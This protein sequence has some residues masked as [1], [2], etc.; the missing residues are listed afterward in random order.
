MTLRQ[1]RWLLRGVAASCVLAAVALVAWAWDVDASSGAAV[2]LA[3]TVPPPEASQPSRALDPGSPTWRTTL[4]RP[5]VDP[6]PRPV[7][8][9]PVAMPKPKPKPV[10]KRRPV[11]KRAAPKP[12]AKP[13]LPPLGFELV[14]TILEADRAVAIVSDAS[15]AIDLRKPG[16]TFELDPPG[17]RLDDVTATAARVRLGNRR[18]TLVLANAAVATDSA[19]MSEAA[20]PPRPAAGPTPRG[21][22]PPRGTSP[23]ERGESMQPPTDRRLDESDLRKAGS[24]TDLPP[25]MIEDLRREAAGE[26]R[27]E[28]ETPAEP[29]ARSNSARGSIFRSRSIVRPDDDR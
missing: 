23:A 19:A 12:I 11:V 13:A 18:E 5:L 29:P 3:R 27:P 8:P 22:Q 20:A 9:P 10:A 1:T 25:E 14:G 24:L 4:R 17:V 28:R 2:A 15:G 6:P 21:M 16:E 26:P 7:E